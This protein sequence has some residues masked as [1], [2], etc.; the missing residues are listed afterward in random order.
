MKPPKLRST[1]LVQSLAL[2]Q[3]AT[4]ANMK[5]AG[6]PRGTLRGTIVDVDDPEERGRVKV[7]FDD[8]NPKIPQVSGAGEWSEKR[9]GKDPDKSH[10]IDV[11]PAFKG[12][13]PKG[14]VGKRVNISASNGQYQ[15]AVL[16]DVLFDPQLLAKDKEKDKEKEE[17]NKCNSE[18]GAEGSGGG[19]ETPEGG[20]E[21]QECKQDEQES[22]FDESQGEEEE[23]EEDLKMPDNSSMT[24]LP[25]YPADELPP[26]C[27][28]NRGCMVI[29]ECGPYGYDW[30]CVCLKRGEEYIWVR[31]ADLQHGHAGA[32]DV[33]S[34]P[35]S[36]G[37]KM[38]PGKVAAVWDQVFV[39]SDA[40]MKKYTAYGTEARGN[41]EG[42]ETKWFPPPMCKDKK[43]LEPVEATLTEEEQ[44]NEFIRDEDEYEEKVP[45]SFDPPTGLPIPD[46]STVRPFPS[47]NFNFNYQEMVQ[48]ATQFVQQQV[49]Q[50]IGEQAAALFQENLQIPSFDQNGAGL[51][52][53][54]TE[55]EEE[56]AQTTDPNQAVS[57]QVSEE[58][59]SSFA[60]SLA[61]NFGDIQEYF[62]AFSAAVQQQEE[63][64]LAELEQTN[65]E[66][67]Q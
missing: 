28:E 21:T 3:Q 51:Q 35:D 19:G 14:M 57:Q 58:N 12:K 38:Q 39:T 43:P 16:Q 25:Y 31:H 40:E 44:S 10:W 61:G 52:G 23:E 37:D 54:E 4:E 7:V 8:M 60:Q 29:E 41:P 9:K 67:T 22:P 62:A 33:T 34:W 49:Q 32:N 59:Q 50:L 24:R 30:V 47:F 17:E 65:T 15:Y 20:S 46:P 27:K 55:E 18:S 42:E 53:S 36:G 26:P 1:P 45:P 66:E 6:L 64:S 2:L 56:E 63:E 48:A 5:F 11:S 13:Q